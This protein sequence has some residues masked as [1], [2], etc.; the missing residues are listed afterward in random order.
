MKKKSNYVSESKLCQ[1]LKYI[2][3]NLTF[4]REDQNTTVLRS[5]ERV[6]ASTLLK[7][8]I[9]LKVLLN[10]SAFAGSPSGK[11]GLGCHGS[12]SNVVFETG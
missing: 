10:K 6:T 11:T 4:K 2:L 7:E 5:V 8:V 1:R 9:T 3:Q 12:N